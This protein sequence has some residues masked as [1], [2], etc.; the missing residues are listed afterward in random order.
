[1]NRQTMYEKISITILLLLLASSYSFAQE[2]FTLEKCKEL[3]IKNNRSIRNSQLELQRAKQVRKE[4]LTSY[5]PSAELTGTGFK[6]KEPVLAT[7]LMEVPIRLLDD[8][9]AGALVLTQPVF[10]GGKIVYGNKLAQLGIE[11]SEQQLRL[12]DNEVL[13]NTGK[14]YWQLISL[15][16]KHVTITVLEQQIDSLLK[17]VQLAY[18]TGLTT[19]N[20]VLQI[21]LKANDLQSA[22]TN[23]TNAITWTKMALCQQIGIGIDQ[24]ENFEVARP[25]ISAVISPLSFFVDHREVLKDRPENVLL[26]KGVEASQLQTKLKRADYLPTVAIGATVYKQNLMDRWSSN[27]VAF[28]SVNIPLSGWWGGSHA[29][30]QQKINEQIAYNKKL[31]GQDQLLLQMQQIKNE[32][33]NAYEQL[34]I[35]Q[36]SIEQ[37]SENLRLN[38]DYY[39]V[40]TVKIT[41]V[42]EAQSLLQKSRDSYVDAYANYQEKTLEYGLA[43]GR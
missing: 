33:T 14:C 22:K 40:G 36:K 3:A 37:A 11:V 4:A 28:L 41:D 39:K 6:A 32:L 31:E 7:Q 8:G 30:K 43:T 9:L 10:T 16:E 5:F 35:A 21:K 17:D 12:S 2:V 13:F 29:V 27:S 15:Y 34:L 23:L 26:E 38:I 25:A 1:M 18:T 19:H 42:L 24:S 20:E